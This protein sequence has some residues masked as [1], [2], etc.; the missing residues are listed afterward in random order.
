MTE[1]VGNAAAVVA[2]SPASRR[3]LNTGFVL[4]AFALGTSENVIAGMLPEI[5]AG[6]GVSESKVGLLVTAYAVTVLF[7]G[8]LLTVAC[9]PFGQKRVIGVLSTLYSVFALVSALAPNFATMFT[10]RVLAG[11]LHT[12][13]L[14]LFVLAAMRAAP[15]DK[16][17]S[18]A[19]TVTLGLSVATVIGVP[20]GVFLAQHV[21]WQAAFVLI[22]VLSVLSLVLVVG[23]LPGEDVREPTSGLRS[24]A[25]LKRPDVLF[26]IFASALVSMAA[27]TVVTYI[28][29][30]LTDGAGVAPS[31]VAWILLAYGAGCVLGNHFGAKIA[32]T[33]LTRALV[34]T[35][36]ATAVALVLLGVVADSAV[37]ATIAATLVG[38]CYFSTFPPL[39]TW[40]ATKAEGLSPSLALSLN[41]SAFNAG[42]AVAAWMGGA[43]LDS[44]HTYGGLPF[45]AVAPAVLALVCAGILF[46]RN[47][48]SE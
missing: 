41:S 25:V 40:V 2:D 31:A 16:K 23:K 9:A 3:L 19:A 36:A 8:P 24:F 30:F 32:N 42:I 17:A 22:A 47:T 27:L 20:I 5:S 35:T 1:T 12:T 43:F 46:W 18:A 34:V 44:G 26:G 13:I 4:G 29:P 37:P 6:L 28:V 7:V 45:V 48:T 15:P 38:L 33:S 21:G 39:N 11:T 14:V 10:T